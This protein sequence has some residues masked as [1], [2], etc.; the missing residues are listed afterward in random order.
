MNL[1]S[2]KL[3]MWTDAYVMSDALVESFFPRCCPRREEGSRQG[4]HQQRGLSGS[5]TPLLQRRVRV[6]ATLVVA[7]DG[8]TKTSRPLQI[9]DAGE[10]GTL[11]S[12]WD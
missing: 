8:D 1:K 4:P 5:I 9:H 3:Q 6:A 11:R 2:I 7:G 12:S 10:G